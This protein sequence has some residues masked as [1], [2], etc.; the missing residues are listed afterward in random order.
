MG[1]MTLDYS[2]GKKRA[3]A[4]PTGVFNAKNEVGH[5]FSVKLTSE[6]ENGNLIALGDYKSLD[7]WEEKAVTTFTGKIIDEIN[8]GEF[9]IQVIEPGDAMLVYQIPEAPET[10]SE[11]FKDDSYFYLPSG[12]IARVFELLKNDTFSVS[13]EGFDGTPAKGK[14]ITGVTGK[15]MVVGS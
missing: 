9:L 7:L 10:Y 11:K 14:S 6:T 2:F 8:D 12:E 3:T 15:K 1:V 13:K 5:S 4:T